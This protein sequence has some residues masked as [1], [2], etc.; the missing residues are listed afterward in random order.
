MDVF[1]PRSPD[2][3]LPPILGIKRA[4]LHRVL[5]GH[6]AGLGL[7]PRLG[8]TVTDLLVGLRDRGLDVTR[9]VLVVI[10]EPHGP[11]PKRPTDLEAVQL[12]IGVRYLLLAPLYGYALHELRVAGD[13]SQIVMR[14]SVSV[15]ALPAASSSSTSVQVP[16]A[17]SPSNQFRRVVA[18]G[19]AM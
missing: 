2:G 4:E 9:P 14:K 10:D 19:A 16:P 1:Y 6:L 11:A 13:G 12:H 3:Q 15:P 7:A 17:F 5:V 18:W 8:T